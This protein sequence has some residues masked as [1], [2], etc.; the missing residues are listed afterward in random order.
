MSARDARNRRSA[1]V[2]FGV[3]ALMLG[4]S[5]AAVP[6]YRLFCQATGYGGTPQ[7]A[8]KGADRRG[9]RDM[10]VMFDGNVAPGLPWT[11]RPEQRQVTVRTGQT[12]TVF[13]KVT[14]RSDKPVT[15]M[16]GYNVSPDQVGVYFNKIACFCFNEQT[17]AAGETAEWPVVF[18]LDPAL[19]RDEVMRKVDAVTLSYT[20][21]PVKTPA[22]APRPASLTSP[23]TGAA[24]G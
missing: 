11:F 12:A 13:F 23:A 4:V 17:L 14:N 15:A 16:A 2:L 8:E 24:R 1:V 21:Y 3:C 6:L 22:A 19:E 9:A 5:F 20:F 7:V 18:F 10:V